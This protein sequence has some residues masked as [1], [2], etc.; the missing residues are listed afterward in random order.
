MN[1]NHKGE[2][3]V[4]PT[5]ASLCERVDAVVVCYHDL[6][7]RLAAAATALDT[8][9]ILPSPS[10]WDA[11]IADM[12]V[13]RVETESL[14]HAAGA[15]LLT[16]A[17]AAAA[18]PSVDDGIIALQD[19]LRAANDRARMAQRLAVDAAIVIARR[20]ENLS[21]SGPSTQDLLV[22]VHSEATSLRA[23]LE[24]SINEVPS[25][26]DARALTDGTHALSCLLRFVDD[27]D[28]LDERAMSTLHA[29]INASFGDDV[30]YAAMAGR[31]HT[32]VSPTETVD[33]S[34]SS[35]DHRTPTSALDRGSVVD[36]PAAHTP[37]E[38]AEEVADARPLAPPSIPV[39]DTADAQPV[40]TTGRLDA[41]VE[42]PQAENTVIT[43]MAASAPAVL[44]HS[45]DALSRS[46]ETGTGKRSAVDEHDTAV[47][48]ALPVAD[49]PASMAAC[50][51]VASAV[52]AAPAIPSAA[53][54]HPPGAPVVAP[55]FIMVDKQVG[56]QA[57][58]VLPSASDNARMTA[59]LLAQDDSPKKTDRSI[60]RG[61][62]ALIWRLLD[63]GMPGLAYY[64]AEGDETAVTDTK[65]DTPP[66]WAIRA[67]TLAAHVGR[68]DGSIASILAEDFA[69]AETAHI[70]GDAPLL[71]CAAMAL[72]PALLAPGTGAAAVL[73]RADLG[74]TFPGLW[75]LCMSLAAYADGGQPLNRTMLASIVQGSVDVDEG[76]LLRQ[77]VAE[78]RVRADLYT[79]AYQPASKIWKKWLEP[80]DVIGALLDAM[81]ADEDNTAP[82]AR[83]MVS[84]AV[85]RLARDVEFRAAVR[86]TDREVVRRRQRED[87]TSG[88]YRQLRAHTNEALGLARRWLEIDARPAPGEDAAGHDP[89]YHR[90]IAR[91]AHDAVVRWSAPALREVDAVIASTSMEDRDRATALRRARA[92]IADVTTLIDGAVV[93][94]EPAPDVL[95]GVDLLA[96]PSIRLA[97]D[98]LRPTVDDPRVTRAAILTYLAGDRLSLRQACQA[99]LE[100]KDVDG[101][102]RIVAHLAV[103][104]PD[105]VD[106][107][108]LQ[109]R[110]DERWSTY[111]ALLADTAQR[112][113][114]GIEGNFMY[115]LLGER[116]RDLALG[117]IEAIT[118]TL[119]TRRDLAEPL[120]T[121][122]DLAARMGALRAREVDRLRATL[123]RVLT[124][125]DPAHAR[126]AAALDAGDVMTAHEYLST[127]ARGEALPDDDDLAP[128]RS[129][130]F[131]DMHTAIQAY[132]S[133]EEAARQPIMSSVV[134]GLRTRA[135]RATAGRSVSH[136][137]SIGP[138]DISTLGPAQVEE[139]A[140]FLDAWFTARRTQSITTDGARRIMDALGFTLHGLDTALNGNYV[141]LQATTDPISDPL[142][143]P[144]ERYGSAAHGR[145][146][147]LCAWHGQ[148]EDAL[149]AEIAAQRPDAPVF[150]WYF[151]RMSA[152]RRRDLGSLCRARRRTCLVIDDVVM[153][154]LCGEQGVRLPALLAA[155]LPFTF[156]E[157]YNT[158]TAGLVPPEMFYGRGRERDEIEKDMGSCLIFG[159]RQLGKTALLLDVA[160]RFHKPA[161]GKIVKVIDLRSE[162]I[163]HAKDLSK[164]W[165]TIGRYVQRAIPDIFPVPDLAGLSD[166]RIRSHIETWLEQDTQRRILL[167]LDEADGFLT[168]DAREGAEAGAREGFASTASLKGLMDR[169][170][171]RFKVVLAGLHNV[172][173]TARQ[174][175]NPLAHLGPPLCI[176]PLL[177]HEDGRAARE[178]IVRPLG[179]LGYRFESPTLV[180]RIL[181]QTNYYP[182]LIQLYCHQLLRLLMDPYAA[183][184]NE[185]DGPPYVITARH[186]DE[187][188][189]NQD[190]RDAIRHRF[191]LTVRLDARY[192]VIAYAMA[193]AV[194]GGDDRGLS[195]GFDLAWLKEQAL[196]WW[197]AGFAGNATDDSFRILLDEM[198]GLGVLRNG[199]GRYAFRSAGVVSMLGSEEDIE[200]VLLNENHADADIYEPAAYRATMRLPRVEM[201]W[202]APVTASQIALIRD[203]VDGVSIVS[204]TVAGALD[205]VPTALGDA[206]SVAATQI[207][208]M[209]DLAHFERAL[210]AAIGGEA[211]PP[212]KGKKGARAVSSAATEPGGLRVVVVAPS[213][214]WTEA[215]VEAAVQLLARYP[216][217]GKLVR[218]V[219]M[220]DPSSVWDLLRQGDANDALLRERG[221]TLAPWHDSVVREW[222]HD[223][224]FGLCAQADQAALASVVNGW[225]IQLRALYDRARGD[226]RAWRTH[227]AA[228]DAALSD[229][230]SAR[231]LCAAFGLSSG[232]QRRVLWLLAECYGEASVDDLCDLG[233]DVTREDVRRGVRWADLLGMATLEK[234]RWR[235]DPVIARCLGTAGP[236]A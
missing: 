177:A 175:N 228:L 84:D 160:R 180:L 107:T 53:P 103:A 148:T 22:A 57:R 46:K 140:D 81:M 1:D 126:I 59:F 5:T 202:R 226:K 231:D 69:R 127:I 150:V 201:P 24:S 212:V 196:S 97:A 222:I 123:S 60:G 193:Q 109:A 188:F 221:V 31:L 73:R 164:V 99:R 157:P 155:T 120:T 223:C 14:Y 25:I 82:D 91:A 26:A 192:E 77:E 13:Y 131:P 132:L 74:A 197:G 28:A 145:Y 83:Q 38:T 137:A 62:A 174:R 229:A 88:A 181:S 122:D 205:D 235:L 191:Q 43:E 133:P 20:A 114:D 198:V 234:G 70:E 210:G 71:L 199:Q 18:M 183:R 37:I 52:P 141:W 15:V 64:L 149:L 29:T 32:P 125:P 95:L 119:T 163:G 51:A 61:K 169:T 2:V 45:D 72:R 190:L 139:A 143:C 55:P 102:E 225:P 167:L 98:A 203:R 162:T 159:G 214:A 63:E 165:P 36:S 80:G 209:A 75:N 47:V 108:D 48:T 154:Y 40:A 23:T 79:M 50:P 153:V 106:L 179:L 194:R 161:E 185:R 184:V 11:V 4:E 166:E 170:N 230:S 213:C 68:T 96:V 151:G 27:R 220:A 217:E 219:F 76:G 30:F 89:E 195:E 124:P 233:S 178:L 118:L 10:G 94:P 92:A 215:W 78:W 134:S 187:V 66:S 42:T 44:A 121:M 110:V 135:E 90:E 3:R 41:S 86:H 87:I 111:R 130:F 207:Q 211:A 8:P 49:V 33:T 16:D 173:R 168:Q 85:E 147:I 7:M 105:A 152:Q 116:E 142:R 67:T 156:L 232:I 218:V 172:Q 204:G 206:F 100:L 112:A 144:V 34:S 189:L 104:E 93:A 158:T 129:P 176:G 216:R 200:S 21:Y 236:G 171:R 35:V 115:G 182:S 138:V 186:V 6:S 54:A 9:G 146:S 17:E 128:T 65:N 136:E 12:A 224:G 39:A 101:A 117:Q 19:A 227:L 208:H 113:R 58:P 56:V